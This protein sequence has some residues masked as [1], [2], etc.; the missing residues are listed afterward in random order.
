MA[1]PAFAALHHT[2]GEVYAGSSNGCLFVGRRTP[3]DYMD[4]DD[5]LLDDADDEIFRSTFMQPSVTLFTSVDH[6]YNDSSMDVSPE[7]V[8]GPVTASTCHREVTNTQLVPKIEFS[9]IAEEYPLPV[10]S[11]ANLASY[12]PS[13]IT[14]YRSCGLEAAAGAQISNSQQG[15]DFSILG[16]ITPVMI[17]IQEDAETNAMTVPNRSSLLQSDSDNDRK[18]PF[19][20]TVLQLPKRY[21]YVATK[22]EE[23]DMEV[24]FTFTAC[25]LGKCSPCTHDSLFARIFFACVATSMG[26]PR[27]RVS[28]ILR[29]AAARATVGNC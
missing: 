3:G 5:E 10:T 4:D 14:N 2:P 18:S 15:G 28:Q 20:D 11:D 9:S 7:F 26:D 24:R 29:T 23:D 12:R 19:A 21:Q 25:L 6:Q 17:P 27:E 8:P 16:R 13:S 22:T 1:T